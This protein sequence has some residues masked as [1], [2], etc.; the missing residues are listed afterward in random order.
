MDLLV[1]TETLGSWLERPELLL[2]DATYHPL[3][4]DRDPR[5]EYEVAHIPGASFLDLAGLGPADP[6][7]TAER[8]GAI[9]AGGDRRI[10]LYDNA[11]HHTAARAWWLMRLFGIADV[12]ILDG[13][14]AKW[15]GEGRPIQSGVSPPGEGAPLGTAPDPAVMRSFDQMKALQAEGATQIVDARSPARFSGREADP[16]P[17]VAPG[18][19]PGSTNLRYDALLQPDGTW[20]RGEALRQAFVAAGVDPDRPVVT[21]CGSGV[22]AAILLFGLHLLGKDDGALYDGSWR[23]WGADPHTPKAVA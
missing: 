5:A 12:A 1:T 21:T 10:V 16:R 17:G 18:H 14:F 6:Q 9:G 22:T 23:E 3:E 11:P 7:R 4:P 2:I 20:K 19:I 13:G 8:L 15:R